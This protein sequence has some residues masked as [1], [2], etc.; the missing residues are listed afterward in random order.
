MILE[1]FSTENRMYVLVFHI[2]EKHKM[3]RGLKIASGQILVPF[4]LKRFNPNLQL[5]RA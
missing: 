2:Q 4:R 3:A 1:T 5:R